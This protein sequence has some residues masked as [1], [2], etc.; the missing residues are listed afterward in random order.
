MISASGVERIRSARTA[1]EKVCQE[2]MLPSAA[3]LDRSVRTLDSTCTQ[4]ANPQSWCKREPHRPE[5][6]Q[7]AR[8][9]QNA[10]RRAS[11]LL[12]IAQDY[13]THWIQALA[14]RSS[15]YTPSGMALPA[16]NGALNLT[17]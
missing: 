2:L 6:L 5:G 14:I 7:E 10:L 3:V 9:F 16:R 17:G 11:D 1:V 15:S 13:H 4:L 12:H 8:L